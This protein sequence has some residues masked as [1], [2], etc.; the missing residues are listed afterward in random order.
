MNIL[1]RFLSKLT[2]LKHLELETHGENDILDGQR[3][4]NLTANFFTFNFKFDLINCPN[5]NL[6]SFRTSFWLEEK[7]W[8]VASNSNSVFS[9]PHFSP[10]ELIL[11]GRLFIDS[12]IPNDQVFYKQVTKLTIVNVPNDKND[13]RFTHIKILNLKCLISFEAL[14]SIINLNQVE[15]LAVSS[16]DYILRFKPLALIMPRLYSLSIGKLITADVIE[17]MRNYQ[18]EQIHN[19][20]IGI[21]IDNENYTIECL[22]RLFPRIKRITCMT[23]INS[24]NNII[25][26]IDG[27]KELSH[28]SFYYNSS[29]STTKNNYYFDSKLNISHRRILTSRI[30]ILPN[31]GSKLNIDLW[32][33]EQINIPENHIRIRWPIRRAFHWHRIIYILNENVYFNIGL[34]LAS[35]ILHLAHEKIVQPIFTKQFAS[36]F[37]FFIFFYSLFIIAW[38]IIF[39]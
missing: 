24:I 17:Q 2:C 10:F 16:L 38:L 37:F 13:Y 6:N 23:H 39:L 7:H 36:G 14:S 31:N 11:P 29:F 3:W 26:L 22:F 5:P 30:Y 20:T 33:T 12:T 27:F 32:L 18:F 1:E 4:Q 35:M 15:Q 28:A 8:F 19:L 21:D 25:R 34:V 9:I